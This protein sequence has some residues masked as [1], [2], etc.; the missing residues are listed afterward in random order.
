MQVSQ[1]YNKRNLQVSNEESFKSATRRMWSF[2]LYFVNRESTQVSGGGSLEGN[3]CGKVCNRED[4][5]KMLSGGSAE[6]WVTG[7]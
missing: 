3:K 1:L 4:K 5:K 2:E 7:R 6:R